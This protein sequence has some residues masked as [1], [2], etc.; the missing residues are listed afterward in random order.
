MGPIHERSNII[1]IDP[2][3]IS[4]PVP[5]DHKQVD[6]ELDNFPIALWQ[7]ITTLYLRK[8]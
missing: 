3:Y 5:H 8:V 4:L 1:F 6:R 2:H 7:G